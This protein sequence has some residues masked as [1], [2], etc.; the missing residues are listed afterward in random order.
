LA[1][2]ASLSFSGFR[3]RLRQM[4]Y[5]EGQ[6]VVFEYRWPQNQPDPLLSLAADL[7]K[8]EVDVIV[9]ADSTTAAAAQRAT[10]QIPIVVAAIS[11]PVA[12]GLVT[13]L[14]RPSGNI[15]GLSL[16]APEI[17]GKQMEL[18]R[19]VVSSLSRVAVLSHP[20]SVSAPTLL[21]ETEQSARELGLLVVRVEVNGAEDIERAFQ[22]AVKA[23]AEAMVVLLAPEFTGIRSLIAKLCLT[24]RLPSISG[25][26]G[27]V[28]AGGLMTYGP[29]IPDLWRRAA[30]YVDRILKGAKP[31]DLPVEQPTTFELMINLR[32]AR[33]LGLTIPVSVLA[34]AD[35]VIE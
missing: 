14:A 21:R 12:D 3:E 26:P 23:H 25:E 20:R 19:E 18:L 27:F 34:R 16:L 6:N 28:E 7:V 2:D 11:D 32:T 13:S 31:G 15:T 17:T 10:T 8:S 5:I 30:F 29:S 1:P 22:G 33:A 35:K 24:N 4:D 9:A